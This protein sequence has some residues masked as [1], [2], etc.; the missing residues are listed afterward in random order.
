MKCTNS[1]IVEIEKLPKDFT[2]RI[3]KCQ[4]GTFNFSMPF[5]AS[6][7]SRYRGKWRHWC[8]LIKKVTSQQLL[9]RCSRKSI[10][11]SIFALHE[12]IK[13]FQR[14][15]HAAT[16]KLMDNSL[17]SKDVKSSRNV[18]TE[19]LSCEHLRL[20]WWR[21]APISNDTSN[22]RTT[23][24]SRHVSQIADVWVCVLTDDVLR[25]KTAKVYFNRIESIRLHFFGQL[26][27]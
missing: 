23:E 22:I 26:I 18:N 14:G 4:H 5:T 13:S 12:M 3:N 10:Y 1:N 8:H 20:F 6:C 11:Y 27:R 16:I 9:H 2:D 24:T 25:N 17:W 19:T 7:V 21:T 15:F